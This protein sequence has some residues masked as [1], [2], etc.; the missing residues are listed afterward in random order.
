LNG[1]LAS[2]IAR[3]W[4][5]VPKH[6]VC[7][8]VRGGASRRG[9]RQHNSPAL[10]ASEPFHGSPRIQDDARLLTLRPPPQPLTR[11]AVNKQEGPSHPPDL[12]GSAFERRA[13]A[14]ADHQSLQLARS[15]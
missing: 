11:D 6:G 4:S 14:R 10:P 1:A 12:K 7:Q 2:L 3:P 8:L 13:A 5:S 15:M 9:R